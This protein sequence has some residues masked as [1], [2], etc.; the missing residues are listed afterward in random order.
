MVYR[1][2]ALQK[3]HLQ[4]RSFAVQMT[5]VDEISASTDLM[6]E[7]GMMGGL[8]CQSSLDLSQGHKV[9][10]ELTVLT[11]SS[12]RPRDADGPSIRRSET[13]SRKSSFLVDMFRGSAVSPV[14][15][16]AQDQR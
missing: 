4:F 7:L 12:S 14:E 2:C 9:A 16:Y 6:S 11:R 8:A 10:K 3:S 5:K 13:R 1:H 15:A